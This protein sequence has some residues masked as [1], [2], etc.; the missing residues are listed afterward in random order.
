[1][2]VPEIIEVKEVLDNMVSQNLITSWELPYEN[3]LT[4]R[5]AAIF[6]LTPHEN[7]KTNLD[8][9]WNQLS[10]FEDFSY[11]ENTEKELSNLSHR[12]TFSKSEKKA[13]KPQDV[14]S[15]E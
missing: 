8:L 1:M 4:R 14:N 6:F 11:R 15:F 5:D 9:I 13:D 12:I 3:L 2:H 10:N 7:T